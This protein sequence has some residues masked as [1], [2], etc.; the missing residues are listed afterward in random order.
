MKEAHPTVMASVP[1]IY[2]K[3]YARIGSQVNAANKRRQ[4][5]FRWACCVGLERSHC[6]QSG[7]PI[8]F[9]LQLQYRLANL[10]VFRKIQAALGGSIR[11]MVSG[12]APIS[13]KILEFFHAAGILVFEGYGLTETTAITTANRVEDYKLGTVGKPIPGVEVRIAEDGE[14]LV[15]GPNIFKGY[16]KDPEK[17][18][19]AIDNEGW[20]H[21]GDVGEVDESG[22]LRITDRKKDLIITAG[23]KNVAPQN[24]ENL[25]K[26]HPL[27][28]QVMVYGDRRKYLTALITLDIEEAR[29]FGQERGIVFTSLS[30]FVEH[31]DVQNFIQARI[32][33]KNQELAR[34]EQIKKFKILPQDFSTQEGTLT[35]TQ[36]VRRR[37]VTEKYQT[38]LDQMYDEIF[39]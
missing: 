5:I 24:I 30:A 32:E 33:E 36:K 2:E 11:F 27:I 26:G 12:G 28:S 35:P 9:L 10:L 37:G 13:L 7:K 39:D 3:A 25:I 19:E 21:T 38:I 8:P 18:A 22:Y 6:I 31:P 23:G 17:T 20:F 14:I 29:I 4:A 16:F 34:Y 15:R 1:R